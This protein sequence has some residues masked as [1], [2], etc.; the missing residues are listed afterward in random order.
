MVRDVVFACLL[1]SRE[2]KQREEMMMK[3]GGERVEKRCQRWV[4]GAGGRV[5]GDRV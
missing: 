5:E 4:F 2:P 3:V 1:L